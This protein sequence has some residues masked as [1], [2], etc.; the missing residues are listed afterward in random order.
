MYLKLMHSY[1]MFQEVYARFCIDRTVS[2]I[3][4]FFNEVWQE[5]IDVQKDENILPGKKYRI[6]LDTPKVLYIENSVPDCAESKSSS[7]ITEPFFT[8]ERNASGSCESSEPDLFAA[9]TPQSSFPLDNFTIP[10]KDFSSRLRQAL[11]DE[12]PLPRVLRSELIHTICSSVVKHSKYPTSVMVTDMARAIVSKYPY[13]KESIGTGYGGWRQAIRD[14][15]KNMRRFDQSE[16]VKQKKITNKFHNKGE[17]ANEKKE[18]PQF[19]KQLMV[20]N[21]QASA[22]SEL[23]ETFDIRRDEIVNQYMKVADLKIKYPNLFNKQHF[24]D[25][26]F[27]ITGKSNIFQCI[28]KFLSLYNKQLYNLLLA[29]K[30]LPSWVETLKCL[31]EQADT[32]IAKDE[33]LLISLPVHFSEDQL[34]LTYTVSDKLQILL[35]IYL[36]IC[37]NKV[38]L[39][40]KGLT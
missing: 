27:R 11:Q 1:L 29:R 10:A 3:I 6:V 25:E 17:K 34:F 36:I 33:F 5:Y 23:N 37:K 28:P 39:E 32:A 40:K 21:E 26:F 2:I 14:K 9:A 38:S 13:L 30:S 19:K 7:H 16:E 4:Q 8:D 20:I 31:Q 22:S 12:V 18:I 15:L 24:A 35:L